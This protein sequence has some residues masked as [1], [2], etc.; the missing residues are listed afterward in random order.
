MQIKVA[1]NVNGG[2][3]KRPL[4]GDSLPTQ[5]LHLHT[6]GS[7]LGVNVMVTNDL[8]TSAL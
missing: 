8:F 7:R 2:N 3:G 4:G 6:N 1:G 5:L